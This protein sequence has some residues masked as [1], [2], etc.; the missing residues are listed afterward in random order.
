MPSRTDVTTLSLD[1]T[2]A[3]PSTRHQV[4]SWLKALET[5]YTI[6][7]FVGA[8][9]S[10]LLIDSSLIG[11][12]AFW[13]I[14]AAICL[15]LSLSARFPRIVRTAAS[16]FLLLVTVGNYIGPHHGIYPAMN[17]LHPTWEQWNTFPLTSRRILAW[18]MAVGIIFWLV[19][20]AVVLFILPLIR[21]RRGQPT[22]LASWVCYLG[23]GVFGLALLSPIILLIIFLITGH[24]PS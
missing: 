2:S 1:S 12:V 20:I 14:P 15:Y 22:N 13:A 5:I 11:F 18:N 19:S 6:G 21:S 10:L 8:L 17:Q 23:V 7:A 4:L 16:L 3:T 9:T 24:F